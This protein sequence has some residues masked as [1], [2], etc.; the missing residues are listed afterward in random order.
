MNEQKSRSRGARSSRIGSDTALSGLSGLTATDFSGYKNENDTGAVIALMVDGHNVKTINEGEDAIIVLNRTPFYAE[1]GGQVGDTGFIRNKT[2]KALISNTTKDKNN[3]YLHH[4]HVLSGNISVGDTV[5]T[6]I[7][8]FRRASIRRNHTA[9][10][11]LQASLRKILGS[12]V[13]QAG[14]LVDNDRLRFDFTHFSPVEK[15]ELN[16]IED[17][18]NDS[19]LSAIPVITEEMPIEEAR[20]TGAMALFGEKYG[21]IVRVVSVDDFSKE[22]CGGTHVS[23]TSDL[24]LFKIISESSVAAGV[25]RIEAVTGSGTLNYMRHKDELLEQTSLAL[26]VN[27]VLDLPM[28]AAQFMSE[29]KEEEHQ[30]N[31]LND[32]LAATQ[33]NSILQSIKE[34]R[35]I[36]I[37]TGIFNDSDSSSL[38]TIID[39]LKDRLTNTAVVA[40][41]SSI[42]NGK[43]S[44]IAYSSPEAQNSGI[45][46]GN[47]VKAV[48]Q[49]AGGNGGGKPDLAMAGV[50]DISKVQYAVE[51]T[52]QIVENMIK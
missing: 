14:Q 10:H 17:M 22:F 1:S 44:L 33:I 27:N 47:L 11:L 39:K 12:H 16:K 19:I 43:A 48:A 34:V 35:G 23:N 41:L 52:Y 15:E 25:R 46:A 9:A 26:K 3:V 38:K 21:A 7:D 32:K 5:T 50:K 28:K 31:I 4:A 45:K 18:V 40:V 6:E 30:L 24:G 8:A 20:K 2:F 13:E 36:K 51:S 42:Q 49:V 37:I 29:K